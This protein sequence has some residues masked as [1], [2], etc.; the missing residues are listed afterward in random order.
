MSWSKIKKAI[1]STIGTPNFKPLDL[2]IKDGLESGSII[3]KYAKE[4]PRIAE[5]TGNPESGKAFAFANTDGIGLREGS[6]AKGLWRF[7][8]LPDSDGNYY[9]AFVPSYNGKQRIGAPNNHVKIIFVDN[10]GSEDHPI[11]VG[12]FN[13]ANVK[14]L[15][16]KTISDEDGRNLITY[17]KRYANFVDGLSSDETEVRIFENGQIYQNTIELEY[18]LTEARAVIS[19]SNGDVYS[20]NVGLFRLTSGTLPQNVIIYESYKPIILTFEREYNKFKISANA[21]MGIEG[22]SSIYLYVRH[23]Y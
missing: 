1:N 23:V 4:A 15:T 5:G 3:P 21:L 9:V 10:A 12:Y 19:M 17:M 13:T 6:N 22:V 8:S 2:L 16:A 11:E 14:N 18:G 20:H 7:W